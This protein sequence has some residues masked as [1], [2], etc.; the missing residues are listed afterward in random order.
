MQSLSS[1]VEQH[2]QLGI[3]HG[4]DDDELFHDILRKRSG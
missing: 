3:I 4:H 1:S 2:R